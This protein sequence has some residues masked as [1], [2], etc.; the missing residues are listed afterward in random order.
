MDLMPITRGIECKDGNVIVDPAEET[1]ELAG[2]LKDYLGHDVVVDGGGGFYGTVTGVLYD[3]L[4]EVDP[5]KDA[6]EKEGLVLH[7]RV[8]DPNRGEG[9]STTWRIPSE[10]SDSEF[11]VSE[12]GEEEQLF[13]YI[14]PDVVTIRR[15]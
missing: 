3:V 9:A 1:F 5:R 10:R 8:I 7:I 14:G 2:V 6:E 11:C 4:V 12:D 15:V 13:L